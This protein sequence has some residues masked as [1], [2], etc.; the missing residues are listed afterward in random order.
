VPGASE[1]ELWGWINRLLGRRPFNIVVSAAANKLAH[2][3]WVLLAH[4]ESW[5]SA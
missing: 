5:R 1:G 4:D 3:V 2:I